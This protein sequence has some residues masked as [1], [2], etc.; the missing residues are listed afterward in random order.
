MFLGSKEKSRK[1][2][3]RREHLNWTLRNRFWQVEIEGKWTTMFK[4]TKTRKLRADKKSF[5][6]IAQ[7]GWQRRSGLGYRRLWL[8][9]WSF[10][11]IVFSMSSGET[12]NVLYYTREWCVQSRALGAWTYLGVQGEGW[13]WRGPT[14]SEPPGTQRT[15]PLGQCSSCWC[16]A[17]GHPRESKNHCVGLIPTCFHFSYRKIVAE[18]EKTIAQMIGEC[19]HWQG[20]RPAL[21][22]LNCGEGFEARDPEC[23]PIRLLLA[24]EALEGGTRASQN[25]ALLQ[26]VSLGTSWKRLPARPLVCSGDPWP[27]PRWSPRDPARIVHLMGAQP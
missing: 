15:C 25:E 11:L 27:S 3:W 12:W 13:G 26:A 23:V 7:D 20:L 10:S 14:T 18:Y 2:S 6:I 16:P 24:H 22:F 17:H 1:T 21:R 19:L 9:G 8:S 5:A 4:A